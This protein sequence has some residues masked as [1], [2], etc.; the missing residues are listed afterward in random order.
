MTRTTLS[1]HHL[2]K[3]PDHT[4]S[5]TFGDVGNGVYQTRLQGSSSMGSG[6]EPGNLH[7]RGRDLNTRSPRPQQDHKN[8]NS[9]DI[10]F[11]N[12]N[13]QNKSHPIAV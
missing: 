3:L 13:S 9:Q 6:F 12:Q 1:W 7:P 5:R 11:L 2:F 8:Q 4:S 10:L